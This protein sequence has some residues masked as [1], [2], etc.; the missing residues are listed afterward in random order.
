MGKIAVV[1]RSKTGYTKKYAEWIAEETKAILFKG[2]D[3]KISDL[4]GF[5]IIVYG[6]AMYAGGINGIKLIKNNFTALKN[7]KIIIFT[8][9]ASPVREEIINSVRN[10]NFNEEQQKLIQFFM[11]RG[12]FDF[13]KLKFMDK[14]L[15]LILKAILKGKKNPT[16]D[17]R[18]MLKSY[19]I[20]F[21]FTNREKIT[22]IIDAINSYNI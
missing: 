12:G 5:D 15:M 9:G 17:D 4:K 20:P 21:D 8:L 18:G 16:A 11:L 13:S 3:I 19:E 10:S 22:P 6:G 1:Y 7:K 14:I 2:E